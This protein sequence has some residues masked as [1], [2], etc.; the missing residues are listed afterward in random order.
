MLDCLPIFSIS[1]E[2]PI[3]EAMLYQM[4]A[5][6]LIATVTLAAATILYFYARG[7][8]GPVSVK[9]TGPRTVAGVIAS[10]GPTVRNRMSAYFSEAG[11][12]YP[13]EQ[14]TMLALKD[15]AYLEVWVDSITNP[16]FVHRYKIQA[17]SGVSGPKLREGDRQVPEG[18]YRIEGLNP[19]SSYHLSMKLDY[20]NSFD[21]K[22]AQAEGRSQPGSNIFIH[23]KAVSIGCLAMGDDAI[24]ELFILVHDVGPGNVRVAIAPT[25]PRSGPLTVGRNPHWVAE[26]YRALENEFGK[27]VPPET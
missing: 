8:W 17:L 6:G 13:P 7:L 5:V 4:K 18:F 11:L 24:E 2:G 26:L 1:V 10:I 23:G 25:D 21:S 20:P 3:G 12:T 14:I 27:Y 16:T 15:S 22:H 19:N 9:L